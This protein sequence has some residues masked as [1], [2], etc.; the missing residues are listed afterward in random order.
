MEFQ[1]SK[2]AQQSDLNGLALQ[3]IQSQVEELQKSN[4]EMDSMLSSRLGTIERVFHDMISNAKSNRTDERKENEALG[5]AFLF[6][7]EEA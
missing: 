7:D 6:S 1:N 4:T 5:I 2:R 3:Q